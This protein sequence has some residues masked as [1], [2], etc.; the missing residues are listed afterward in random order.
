M[1]YLAVGELLVGLF[2]ILVTYLI[3][4]LKREHQKTLAALNHAHSKEAH[5][6]NHLYTR[7]A[8][9]LE[10]ASSIVGDL[11]FWAEKCVVPRT[12]TDFGT[13]EEIASKMSKAFE[14][15][16]L[17][18]M[19]YPFVFKGVDGFYGSMGK[20]MGCV[21]F[22]ENMANSTDFSSKS[23][24]WEEA[25]ERFQTELA[26]LSQSIQDEVHKVMEQI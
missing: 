15:L 20:L 4:C 18:A 22:I 8:S 25:V 9:H 12:R 19:K 5:A 17:H 1:E 13:K 2:S 21:N 26:P 10:Q 11:K 3:W 16:S 14:D 23:K 7:K 6:A 24:A